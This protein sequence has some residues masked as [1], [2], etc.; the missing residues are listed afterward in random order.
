M[1]ILQA[2][3]FGVVAYLFFVVPVFAQA[4]VEP[5]RWVQI[6]DPGFNA[7]ATEND[8][9]TAIHDA[10]EIGDRLFVSTDY[11]MFYTT[12]TVAWTRL[13]IGDVGR[14]ET[15]D[16]QV[17]VTRTFDRSSSNLPANVLRCSIS[18][19]CDSASEW[20]EIADDGFGQ[21]DDV[22]AALD[23]EVI[24]DRLFSLWFGTHTDGRDGSIIAS[25]P[26]AECVEQSDWTTLLTADEFT[27]RFGPLTSEGST[28][29][30]LKNVD[31]RLWVGR[32]RGTTSGVCEL[33][34]GCDEG[35]DYVTAPVRGQNNLT[36]A[37]IRYNGKW[38]FPT[39]SVGIVMCDDVE[40][41]LNQSEDDVIASV[42]FGAGESLTGSFFHLAVYEDTL[43]AAVSAVD[44]QNNSY[45]LLYQCSSTCASDADW[46]QISE[47][48]FGLPNDVDMVGSF[49]HPW[50]YVL[51]VHESFG[52][53][54]VGTEPPPGGASLLFAYA[55]DDTYQHRAN[56]I[57][58]SR[59]NSG[60]A[61]IKGFSSR[62]TVLSSTDFNAYDGIASGGARMAL[63]D[64]D[65]DGEGELVVGAS[66]GGGPHVR[67]FERDGSR[68][69][70]SFF[71]FHPDF[72]GGIDVGCADTDGDGKDEVVASQFSGGQ[73]WVKVYR[74]NN[75][76]EVI[77]TWN[78]F[79]SPEV[80]ATVTGCDIDADGTDEICVGAGQ[81]G[82]PQVRVFEP[83]GTVKP[84]QFFAF[85]PDSRTGVDVAAGD[86][87]G[88]GKD[89]I[90]T[91]Q[92]RGGQGWVKVY[93]YSN[94]RPVLG[95]WNAFG[96]PES[97]ANV[98]VADIDGN[99][100][101]DVLVGMNDTG[102]KVKSYTYQ[103][104]DLLRTFDAY[105]VGFTGG[106]L[107][108]AGRY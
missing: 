79:G 59:A 27:D 84:I 12:D 62:G 24:G 46:E 104:T 2:A 18:T 63:C 40:D 41:C 13:D 32:Y 37:P 108:V 33:S 76:Q 94:Q 93:R 36:H 73:G 14:F 88:D 99:G 64:I 74:Y 17:F 101:L 89:E 26:L 55:L 69:P 30:F 82:G 102:S 66:R 3:L 23:L 91:A 90:V 21:G 72:R 80:G 31:G 105:E 48:Q 20:T 96:E 81:G 11:G 28:G 83:D 16:T 19:G 38:L 100:I 15:T 25:C 1:R 61:Q 45:V 78:A 85:H 50:A 86:V 47:N 6:A 29:S 71:A 39:S 34:T 92:L 43:Y 52:G 77:G 54:L 107:P 10:V 51:G 7:A 98:E 67:V 70:I 58:T 8:Y 44:G 56:K 65:Q 106:A 22:V 103:G 87:D 75:T 42:D 49:Y 5:D 35:S 97:G 9:A 95:E 68:R 57:F 53:L 60:T 4:A